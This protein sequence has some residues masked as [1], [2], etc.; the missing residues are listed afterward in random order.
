MQVQRFILITHP[1]IDSDPEIRRK[2]EKDFL[3]AL[4]RQ[5]VICLPP[6]VVGLQVLTLDIPEERLKVGPL[7]HQG[8][9][10]RTSSN[11][12]AR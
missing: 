7:R 9:V 11:S 3:E 10:R 5:E 1:D 2:L 12:S 6:G 4:E 8:Q